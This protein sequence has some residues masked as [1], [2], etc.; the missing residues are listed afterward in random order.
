MES[1]GSLLAPTAGRP[2]SAGELRRA[3]DLYL[4]IAYVS[5][6]V[7][8]AVL[9]RLDWS[10]GKSLAELL[11]GPP[12]ERVG[13]AKTGDAIVALRLGNSRYPHMKLQIQAWDSSDGFL[14]SVN[15]HDQVLSLD[16][17][18]PEA[19]AFQ[20]LQAEN[21]RTKEAIEQAWDAAGLP[22]FLRFLRDYLAANAC[23]TEPR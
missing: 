11:S 16:P 5:A 9:K 3:A 19:P 22:T 1:V 4:S 8:G 23:P 20:S 13:T 17:N 6:P 15:T 18:S 12:F 10:P 21:Q 7:P 14:L 2:L